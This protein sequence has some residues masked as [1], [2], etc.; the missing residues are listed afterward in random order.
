MSQ[1]FPHRS[2]FIQTALPMNKGVTGGQWSL[3]FRSIWTGGVFHTLIFKK[4]IS[5]DTDSRYHFD[6]LTFFLLTHS[7]Y[8]GE[9]SLVIQSAL[10]RKLLSHCSLCIV[11]LQ[12]HPSIQ[13]LHHPSPLHFKK[14]K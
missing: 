11:M 4:Q 10:A 1:S 8:C 3:N 2:L 14:Y 6:T 7:M 5:S 12:M 13:S 9:S